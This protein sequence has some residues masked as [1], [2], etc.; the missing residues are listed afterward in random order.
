MSSERRRYTRVLPR[1]NQPIP[2]QLVSAPLP[3][4]PK[5]K[6]KLGNE[7]LW[8][9]DISVGGIAVEIHHDVDPATLAAEVEI[10][11]SLPDEPEFH[12]RAAVR[13]IS[14]SAMMFGVQFTHIS[15]EDV[16]RIDA[17][18]RARVLEGGTAP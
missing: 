10:I 14:T 16:G 6:K 4:A 1:P 5:T 12:A 9:R 3:G 8:A 2:V 18:V 17:Y 11:V 15:P 13:H 7:I